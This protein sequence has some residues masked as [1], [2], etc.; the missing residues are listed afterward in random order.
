MAVVGVE[1][2]AEHLHRTPVSARGEQVPDKLAMDVHARRAVE[3]EGGPWER[4]FP[5]APVDVRILYLTRKVARLGIDRA[6]YRDLFGG[7]CVADFADEWE[8]LAEEGL[9]EVVPEAVRLTPRGTFYGDTVAG[10]LAWRRVRA[11]AEP[12]QPR[13]GRANEAS[14][15]Y[16]G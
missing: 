14:R 4:W 12:D 3:R 13:P 2:G 15:Q 16:M 8:A 7:D 1:H 5:F 9:V 11:L 10:L 6:A